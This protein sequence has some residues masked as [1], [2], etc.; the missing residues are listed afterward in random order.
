MRLSAEEQHLIALLRTFDEREQIALIDYMRR[1]VQTDTL[2]QAELQNLRRSERLESVEQAAALV[3]RRSGA[4]R[5]DSLAF[6]WRQIGI[7]NGGWVRVIAESE[8][9]IGGDS[10]QAG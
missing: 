9:E 3:V 6:E 4:E 7:G 1:W 10:E 2:A 8:D 5:L